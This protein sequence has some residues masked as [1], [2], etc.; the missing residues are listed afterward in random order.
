MNKVEGYVLCDEKNGVNY[1]RVYMDKASANIAI[2]E[3]FDKA[4]IDAGR[5]RILPIGIVSYVDLRQDVQVK[6]KCQMCGGL[7][8][9]KIKV[10][11]TKVINDM[12]LEEVQAEIEK[13][14][15]ENVEKLGSLI[16]YNK[17]TKQDELLPSDESIEVEVIKMGTCPACQGKK[18]VW[19]ETKAIVIY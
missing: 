14:N 10:K 8:K 2:T 9:A 19:K 4:D 1:R 15:P 12:T 6:D 7:G 16:K 3:R 17:K 5:V 13:G 11:E 18:E